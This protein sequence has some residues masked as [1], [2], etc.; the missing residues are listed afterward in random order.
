LQRIWLE[1]SRR[2][3]AADDARETV[4][5]CEV[6]PESVDPVKRRIA[7]LVFR[8]A[9]ADLGVEGVELKWFEP[10]SLDQSIA[11]KAYRV[12]Y[13]N[14]PS[15]DDAGIGQ[16]FYEEPIGGMTQKSLNRIWLRADLGLWHLIEASSH[17]VY[18][19]AEPD[20][21][22]HSKAYA[23]GEQWVAYA[24][25]LAN[26]WDLADEQIA[27]RQIDEALTK[28]VDQYLGADPNAPTRYPQ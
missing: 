24:K 12:R 3:A 25:S 17:E 23:Y 21:A 15:H 28:S 6:S 14:D 4:S 22:D 27:A 1:V 5:Y 11:R 7:N 26:I 2:Q 16:S 18:H 19:A 20:D 10:E 9:C 8:K 13:G